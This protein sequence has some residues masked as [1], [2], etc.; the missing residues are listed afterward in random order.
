MRL[1]KSSN[2]LFDTLAIICW[3]FVII[4]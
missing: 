4:W 1:K 2:V 3:L